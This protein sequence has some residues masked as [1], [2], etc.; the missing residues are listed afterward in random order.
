MNECLYLFKV[1]DSSF[2]FL[3]QFFNVC[4]LKVREQFDAKQ[5]NSFPVSDSTRRDVV[6]LRTCFSLDDGKELFTREEP[7]EKFHINVRNNLYEPDAIRMRRMP[8]LVIWYSVQ[9]FPDFG[10]V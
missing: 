9:G 6:L 3:L 1:I 5:P 2:M 4:N 10:V 8:R 7:R